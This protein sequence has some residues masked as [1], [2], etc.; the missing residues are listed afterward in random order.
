[1]AIRPTYD[2]ART[3]DRRGAAK[4]L[5]L[6]AGRWLAESLHV[7]A[8]LGIAD[9]LARGPRSAEYLAKASASDPAALARV[10]RA[11]AGSGVFAEEGDCFALTPISE[12]LRSDIECSMRAPAIF[13]GGQS[14]MVDGMLLEC[15]RSGTSAYRE[16]FG[17]DCAEFYRENPAMAQMYDE[18]GAALE[19]LHLSGVIKAYNFSG[20]SLAVEVHGGEFLLKLLHGYPRM[21]GILFDDPERIEVARRKFD[22][23]RFSF[24]CGF[25]AGRTPHS[26]PKGADLYVLSGV[27]RNCDDDRAMEFLGAIADAMPEASRLLLCE[28]PV[29]SRNQS[30]SKLG[31][32]SMLLRGRGRERTQAEYR[33]LLFQAGLRMTKAI[34]TE[35]PT[36]MMLLEAKP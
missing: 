30:Y 16:M 5:D 29:P 23:A 19:A 8:V 32:I 28:A 4:I 2:P 31:D 13:F 17:A 7:V 21:R 20:I 3:T 1:M 24:R 10:M 18:T 6:I 27:L 14:A 35:S 22:D 34:P 11:L 25:V 9:L 15:V 26:I 12:F 33:A 36:G